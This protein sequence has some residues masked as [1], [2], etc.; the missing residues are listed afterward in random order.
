MGNPPLVVQ[1]RTT[2]AESGS[3]DRAQEIAPCSAAITSPCIESLTY[4]WRMR[5]PP[6]RS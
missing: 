5:E 6:R 4:S 3:D 2:M 1:D